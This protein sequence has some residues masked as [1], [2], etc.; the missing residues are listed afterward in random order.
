MN[1]ESEQLVEL[2]EFDAYALTV[3]FLQK[4]K[5]IFKWNST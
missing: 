4:L 5:T 1:E 3:G 2:I